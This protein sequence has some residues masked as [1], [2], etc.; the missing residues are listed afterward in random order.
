MKCHNS[1]LLVS[2]GMEWVWLQGVLGPLSLR[3]NDNRVLT[4]GIS[5]KDELLYMSG[6]HRMNAMVE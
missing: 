2:A 4:E 6:I 3:D 1:I 5:L